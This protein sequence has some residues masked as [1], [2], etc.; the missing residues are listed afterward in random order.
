MGGRQEKPRRDEYSTA[1]VRFARVRKNDHGA[2]GVRH[3][4]VDTDR[5]R[6]GRSAINGL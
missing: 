1:E 4:V 2:D 5:G 6:V 3:G